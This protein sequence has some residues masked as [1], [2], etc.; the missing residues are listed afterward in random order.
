MQTQN[1]EGFANTSLQAHKKNGLAVA[2]LILG[3]LSLVLGG[4]LTAIPGI[5]TGHMAR[6]RIRNYPDQYEGNGMAVFGLVLSY[7]VLI[8]SLL[9]MA[10]LAYLYG[11]GQLQPMLDDLMEQ[12]QV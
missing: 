6:S 3:V 2:S 5:I 12:F 7:F 8:F 11:T 9:V 10:G 1:T 4:I